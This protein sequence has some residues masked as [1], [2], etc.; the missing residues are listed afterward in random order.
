MGVEAFQT[1]NALATPAEARRTTVGLRSGAVA[2][3]M[4]DANMGR[5]TAILSYGALLSGFAVGEMPAFAAGA[6]RN[7]DVAQ[8]VKDG[9]KKIC[10]GGSQPIPP[11][12]LNV[13]IVDDGSALIAGAKLGVAA[14]GAKVVILK[15]SAEAVQD[16]YRQVCES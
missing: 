11:D 7:L 15:G 4:A 8:Q 1:P 2:V 6:D 9:V 10:T 5:R 16:A 3:S 13:G 12:A 14:S